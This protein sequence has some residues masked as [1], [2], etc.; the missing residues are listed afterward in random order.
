M[1]DM[2]VALIS[3]FLIEE[4]VG[5]GR[6]VALSTHAVVS[7]KAYYLI[8]PRQK[9]TRLALQKFRDW[10]VAEATAWQAGDSANGALR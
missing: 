10:V 3:A 4:E 1:H 7:D 5:A 2:G 8:V 9:A 6:L